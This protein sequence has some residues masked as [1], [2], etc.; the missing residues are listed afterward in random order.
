VF[1]IKIDDNYVKFNERGMIERV[2]S[3]EE[4]SKLKTEKVAKITIKELTQRHNFTDVTY[5]QI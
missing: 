2:N 3:I 5:E 1:V 4:A